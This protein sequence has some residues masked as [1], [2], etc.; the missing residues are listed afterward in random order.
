MRDKGFRG[1]VRVSARQ[2]RAAVFFIYLANRLR[3]SK[4]K[5]ENERADLLNGR[6]RL[7]LFS[8][9]LPYVALSRVGLHLSPPRGGVSLKMRSAV[10]CDMIGYGIQHFS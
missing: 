5:R 8:P 9:P 2:N 1:T 7:R 3:R 4:R 6:M 10:P